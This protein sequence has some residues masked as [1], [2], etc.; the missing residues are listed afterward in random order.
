[1][2]HCKIKMIDSINFL[3]MALAKLPQ[4]FGFNEL[5]KGYFPHLFNRKENQS[6]VMDTLPDISY[7]TPDSMKPEAKEEFLKWYRYKQHKHDHFD[8]QAE[9]LG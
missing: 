3:P 1:M 5:K 2:P 9:L 4:T 6:V 8:I 7:Y